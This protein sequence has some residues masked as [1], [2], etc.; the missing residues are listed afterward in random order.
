MNLRSI[1]EDVLARC[2][3]DDLFRFM[4]FHNENFVNDRIISLPALRSLIAI[5]KVVAYPE[6]GLPRP[7]VRARKE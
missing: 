4:G 3:I 7:P 6:C 1:I 2:F 5:L